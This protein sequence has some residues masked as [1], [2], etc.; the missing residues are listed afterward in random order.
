MVV[1]VAVLVVVGVVPVV[2]VVM[3][4][5]SMIV[6]FC[7]G[8]GG[9]NK[10]IIPNKLLF[11]PGSKIQGPRFSQS[12]PKKSWIQGNKRRNPNKPLFG[13]GSKIQDSPEVSSRNFGPW[14]LDPGPNKGL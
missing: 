3:V 9:P 1:L 8:S 14:I 4:V 2:P 11:G 6:V 5:I 13:P 12:L 7:D 10:R